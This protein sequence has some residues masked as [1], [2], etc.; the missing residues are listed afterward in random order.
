VRLKQ[1]LPQTPGKRFEA[2]LA[3]L[4]EGMVSFLVEG[5]VVRVPYEEIAAVNL[6]M[7]I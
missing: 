3:G 2:E 7:E 1:R 5:Q 6:V 4:A